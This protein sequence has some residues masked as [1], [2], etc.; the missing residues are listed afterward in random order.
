MD[1]ST[2]KIKI[3]IFREED[4]IL[5]AGILIK[6]GYTVRSGKARKTETGKTYD[7]FLE[8]FDEGGSAGGNDGR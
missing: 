3:K 7:Y 6:N 5:V 1:S 4:R 8:I 2:D